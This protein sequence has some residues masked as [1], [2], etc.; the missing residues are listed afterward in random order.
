MGIRLI[1]RER[2]RE[3]INDGRTLFVYVYEGRK[4]RVKI[5]TNTQKSSA[6]EGR[7]S[8]SILFH[9][10]PNRFPT[11]GGPMYIYVCTS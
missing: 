10:L 7:K 6:N 4:K 11:L 5:N 1:T 9:P 3:K 8:V 2:Q